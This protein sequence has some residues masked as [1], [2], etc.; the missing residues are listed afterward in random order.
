VHQDAIEGDLNATCNVTDI[1]ATVTDGKLEKLDN[2]PEAD[3]LSA[4]T[5]VKRKTGKALDSI[6]SVPE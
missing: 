5:K 1:A 6:V 3:E 4:R 2:L